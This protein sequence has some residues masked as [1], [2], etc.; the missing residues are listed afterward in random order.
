MAVN[1]QNGE[2]KLESITQKWWF[3]LIFILI[4]FIIPPY[5]SKGYGWSEVGL[6]IREILSNAV[7]FSYAGLFPIFK[8][9][10]IILIVSIIIFRNRVA[11]IFSVYV[12]VTYVLFAFLQNIAATEK[13]GLGI[14]TA[15]LVMFLIVAIFCFWEAIAQKNDFTPRTQPYGNIGSS[16]LLFWRFGIRQI[17]LQ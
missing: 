15:N 10:P 8:I 4:Q 12:G 14:I 3:F 6:F 16:P 7:V 1:T 17:R 11:R 9:I 2:E 5:A 13:Y